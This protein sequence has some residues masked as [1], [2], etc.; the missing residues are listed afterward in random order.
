ECEHRAAPDQDAPGGLHTEVCPGR[1]QR[2]Q[3]GLLGDPTAE[4]DTPR[5]AEIPL[6][7]H[8]Q[9][10]SLQEDDPDQDQYADEHLARTRGETE[11]R[12]NGDDQRQEERGDG[13]AD[14][15]GP[16]A[17][18][19]GHTQHGS[20]DAVEGERRSDLGVADRRSGNDEEGGDGGE[21]SGDEQGPHP[22][23]IG[24]D[25]SPLRGPLVEADGANSQAGTTR[26]EPQVEESGS[27]DEED[28]GDG[29]GTYGRRED[30]DQ[31]AADR[32]LGGRSQSERDTVE[33]AEGG[34]GGDDRWDL[35]APDQPGIDQSEQE[36]A[37]QHRR[38]ADDDLRGGGLGADEE[39]GDNHA[40][41]AH[42]PDGEVEIAHEDGVG[43]AD[44][45][46]GERH[47]QQQDVVDVGGVHEPVEPGVGVSQEGGD[48]Q[49]LERHRH[50]Q[51]TV[52]ELDT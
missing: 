20:G 9:I 44:R 33:D 30:L 32:S 48:Q 25:P 17:G 37:P 8:L 7:Q 40:E 21:Q 41:A 36:S 13:R 24:A 26:V 34:Q 47:R 31:A 4:D 38:H 35:D 42:R 14:E 22:D 29:N 3:L 2:R 15:R 43:L 11:E 10:S 52:G 46:Y 19:R 27:D 39:G 28:E 12:K 5:P 49:Q 16:S 50:P 23:P 6:D 1:I 51:A 18:E 45:H